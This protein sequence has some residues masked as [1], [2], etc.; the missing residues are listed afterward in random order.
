MTTI[1]VFTT[2]DTQ[3]KART[4][5]NALVERKLAACVQITAIESVYSWQ[6]EVHNDKEFRVMAKT[7]AGRY[8]EV[9]AVIREL[10]TYDLPAIYAVDVALISAPYA[11]WVAENSSSDS[12]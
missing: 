1:A 10:H 3:E 11:D 12:A 9:E 7:V 8:E 4:I 2:I 6:G 5:A